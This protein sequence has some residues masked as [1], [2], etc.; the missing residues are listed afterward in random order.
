MTTKYY[1]NIGVNMSK[2]LT[3]EQMQNMSIDNIINMYR[4]GYTIDENANIPN[5]DN[6]NHK[7]VSADIS[8]GTGSLL[9]IGAGLLLYMYIRR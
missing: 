3:L 8:I 2:L 7:I 6:L 5:I 1:N 4:D 9:L